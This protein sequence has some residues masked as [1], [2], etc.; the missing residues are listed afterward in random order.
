FRSGW[1]QFSTTTSTS[2]VP[3]PCQA[4]S[5]LR[6]FV[7]TL[8]PSLLLATSA[9]TAALASYPTHGL[10]AMLNSPQS[11]PAT[12]PSLPTRSPLQPPTASTATRARPTPAVI[13]LRNTAHLLCLHPRGWCLDTHPVP[14]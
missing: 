4:T 14:G 9:I 13:L 1:P 11:P 3:K 8:Q 10:M 2:P 12:L 7:T 6:S 5:S